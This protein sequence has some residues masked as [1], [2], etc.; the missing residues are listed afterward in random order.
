[1]AVAASVLWN[2]ARGTQ[3]GQVFLRGSAAQKTCGIKW[4]RK[5][6]ADMCVNVCDT[7]A[8]FKC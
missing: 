8:S 2:L 6:P 4:K 3:E 1:M 5:C 7:C